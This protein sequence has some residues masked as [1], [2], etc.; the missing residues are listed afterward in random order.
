MIARKRGALV[1]L[2]VASLIAFAFAAIAQ[3][4]SSNYREQGGLRWVIGGSLDVESGG[5]IDIESGGA[6]KIDG[7]AVT[8]TAAELNAVDGIGGATGLTLANGESINTNTDGTFD[9]TRDESGAVTIAY[10]DDDATTSVIH[11]SATLTAYTITTDDTGDGTDLV[12]P[13]NAVGADELLGADVCG[14]LFYAAVDPTEA[15]ATDDFMS[16]FDHSGS[17]TEG[18]EDEFIANDGLLT[19]H[20]LR[21]DTATAPGA[22]KDAYLIVIR[23]DGGDTAVTCTIDETATS[24]A[25]SSNSAVVAAGSL[26]NFDINSD[27]GAGTD[28]DASALMTCSVC[29]GP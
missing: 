19:V 23:D 6:L 9:F 10:S 20:S 17:T 29:M 21:C 7:T 24:C 11:G 12:L 1:A 3:L 15:G 2:L 28:P 4:A 27:V 16:F 14:T 5:E 8:S 18:N 22:G 25:D 26:M 13:D